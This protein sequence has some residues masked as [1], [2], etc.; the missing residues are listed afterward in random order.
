M[1]KIISAFQAVSIV[2]GIILLIMFFVPTIIGIKPC[3]VLS[4]SMEPQIKTGSIVYANTHVEVGTIK[5]GDIIVF[6][7]GETQVIHRVININENSFITKGDANENEDL[8]PVNL[9]QYKGK[10]IFS[11]PY[12]GKILLKC[13]TR[14]GK[15][16]VFSVIG[17]NILCCLYAVNTHDE[18]DKEE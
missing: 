4:G 14:T 8:A 9:S 13:K 3:I 2:I 10:Y 6:N 18:D 5:Q 15:F 1:K 7:I 11:I 17:L 12:L 16:I